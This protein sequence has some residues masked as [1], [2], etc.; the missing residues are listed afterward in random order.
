MPESSL[1]PT[2]DQE[3]ANPEKLT[4]SV[5]FYHRHQRVFATPLDTRLEIGRQRSGE[6]APRRRIDRTGYARIVLA[7]FDDVDISRS[8]LALV[9]L[10]ENEIEVTNLSRSQPV[11]LS[12]EKMLTPGEKTITSPP[13]LAQFSSY[14]VRVEPPLEE[15]LDLQPLPEATMPP[16][17]KSVESG[18]G[19]LNIDTMDER[20]LL[21]WLETVLGVFQSAANSRDFPVLAAKA[22]VK[23]VGLDAAAMIECDTQ[24]RWN[25]AAL[26]SVIEG[27]SEDTWVPSQTLLARVL[28][29]RRTF[30]HVPANVPDTAKSLQNVLA[31]VAAPILD[32]DGRV[33]G[34]LY[35]DRRGGGSVNE[36]PEISPFEAKLVEVL[37]SGIAAGLARV[38]EEKAAMAARVQFEQFFTPQ[39]AAQME[40]DPQLLDGRDANITVLFADI[41]GFSRISEQLGPART[42]AWIQDVM[43]TLSE[44]VLEC[45]GVLVDFLG[46]EIMAMWGAPIAQSDHADLACQAAMKMIAS[47]P[48]INNRW[49]KE[50]PSPVCLGIGINSGIARVGNTGSKQKFKYGPLGDTVNIASR[51]QGATKYLGTDCLITGSTRT[52][53]SN[54]HI[55][56]R[57]ACVK[58]VNIEQPLELFEL[59]RDVP[60][61]WQA[62]CDRYH[63]VLSALEQKNLTLAGDLSAKL[64]NEFPD[65]LAALALAHRI[66]EARQSHATADSAIWQLPGK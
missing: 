57:L 1:R 6:P 36:I 62:H 3:M 23:I 41:R 47:L 14:A 52:A 19:R 48:E 55:T 32:G 4:L 37:A 65:D 16:G 2:P 28:Q 21:R 12:R 9:A 54:A 7:P 25:V 29:E 20:L 44:C 45:D 51:V 8:H 5:L 63:E 58:V 59:V 22:L 11:R 53:L 30:R 31:L 27:Q 33:L 34:V 17:P 18:L 49:Q 42:M 40:E 38:K 64:R 66:E 56:R 61:N 43:G 60:E 46:D 26:H 24:N 15:D 10:N 35:G 50:L 39:L 13:L